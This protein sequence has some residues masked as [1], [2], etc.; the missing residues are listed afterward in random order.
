VAVQLD[1]RHILD[2]AVGGKHALL[3]LAAEQGDL[4]LLTLVLVRVVL[5]ALES[6]LYR[7]NK[8]SPTSFPSLN[9]LPVWSRCGA[10]IVATADNTFLRRRRRVQARARRL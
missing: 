9:T 3:V 6:S 7:L 5:D 10:E 4:D 2:R 8:R 1:V